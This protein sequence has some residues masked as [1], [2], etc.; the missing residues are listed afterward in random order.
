MERC[1]VQRVEDDVFGSWFML[2]G[3]MRY[4]FQSLAY[5]GERCKMDLNVRVSLKQTLSSGCVDVGVASMLADNV[6]D[7]VVPS[8]DIVSRYRCGFQLLLQGD[9]NAYNG[10]EEKN[11]S[12]E[13]GRLRA[14]HCI[15]QG[16]REQSAG[17]MVGIYAYEGVRRFSLTLV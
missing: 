15:S 5:F 3:E 1:S 6:E 17:S 9:K 14:S 13:H 7:C 11:D 8:S 16:G 12:G 10:D 4:S 2:P